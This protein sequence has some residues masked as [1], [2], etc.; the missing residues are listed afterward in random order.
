MD[1]YEESGVTEIRGFFSDC[2]KFTFPRVLV[3]SLVKVHQD[4]GALYCLPGLLSIPWFLY[5]YG[6]EEALNG[7]L[8][9]LNNRFMLIEHWSCEVLRETL[10]VLLLFGL[11]GR[12]EG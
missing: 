11:T 6:S 4:L 12:L 7:N 1:I 9:M 5:H 10:S 2:K 8:L 3:F